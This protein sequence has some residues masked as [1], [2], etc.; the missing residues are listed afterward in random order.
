MIKKVPGSRVQGSGLNIRKRMTEDRVLEVGSGNAEVGNLDNPPPITR[1][2]PHAPCSLARST[3][4]ALR[5]SKLAPRNQLP[6][7]R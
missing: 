2:V 1:S 3:K 6:E 4:L 7:D 5:T